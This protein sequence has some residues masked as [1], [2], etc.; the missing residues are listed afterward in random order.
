MLSCGGVRTYRQAW[1]ECHVN[2]VRIISH[3]YLSKR[4]VLKQ[5]FGSISRIPVGGD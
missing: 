3:I 1:P 4:I 5:S 2:S